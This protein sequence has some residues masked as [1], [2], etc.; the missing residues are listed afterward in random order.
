MIIKKVELENI[1]SYKNEEIEFPEGSTV[2]SG[3]I[4]SGKTSVLLGIEFAL[5][6]LQPGQRGNSLLRNGEDKGRVRLEIEVDNQKVIVERGLERKSSSVSQTGSKIEINGEEKE[7]AVTELKN[8]VLSILN[9]PQE[10]ARKT[11]ILYRFTVYT[12]QENM[13][14]IILEK[15]EARLNT[16]RHIFGI[17]KY[18]KIKENTKSVT[19]LLRGKIRNYEGQIKNLEKLKENLKTEKGNLEKAKEKITNLNKKLGIQKEERKDFQKGVKKVE[20]K[21]EEKRKYE[22]EAEK[23][24][25]MLQSKKERINDLNK[26]KEDIRKQIEEAKKT[27]FR[28]EDLEELKKELEEKKD[29]IEKENKE[30]MEIMTKIKSLKSKISDSQEL[31][32]KISSLATCPTCFQDVSSDYKKNIVR[33]C[34]NDID[35]FNKKITGFEKEKQEKIEKLEMLKKGKQELQEKLQELNKLKIKLEGIKEKEERLS[36]LDREMDK[37]NKDV[38]MLKKQISSLKESASELKKYELIYQKKKEELDSLL[39]KE[40]EI[41]ISLASVKKE[42]EMTGKNIDNLRE[43]I[44]DKREVK[45]KLKDIEELEDWLSSKFLEIVS[46]TERNILLKLREEFSKLFNEWFNILVPEIFTV[47]LDEDFTP[48]I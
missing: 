2:L 21:K 29:S 20:E 41:K 39:K 34:D 32:N 22:Q 31:K 28:E 7:M 48:V 37:T 10:F 17:D 23:A 8:R 44:K 1:R 43:E 33:K 5:F 24:T 15:S 6:G 18:K 9:Y 36:K 19:S 26:E 4:G 40:E 11:N 12:P 46:F 27:E 47:S 14:Q 42:K 30:Y 38:E 45:K 3:D 35:L 13:K 25:V 16:L